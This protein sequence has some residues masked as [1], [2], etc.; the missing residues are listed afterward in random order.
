MSSVVIEFNFSPYSLSVFG[1]LLT[2]YID[3]FCFFAEYIAYPSHLSC[4]HVANGALE[5][6]I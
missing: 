1:M 5:L 2:E 4:V 6:E 3:F